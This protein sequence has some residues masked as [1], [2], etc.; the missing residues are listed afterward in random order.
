M[1]YKQ[2]IYGLIGYPIEHSRSPRLFAEHSPLRALGSY[3]LFPLKQI[4]DLSELILHH[5]P[6]G[7]NV[8]SPYKEAVL[9]LLPNVELS[10]EVERI[11]ATNVLSLSYEK[12]QLSH[13]KAYNTD[14]FGFAKSLPP[15]IIAEKPQ[16]LILGTGGAA[17]AVALALEQL[18]W[19]YGTY[20]LLSRSPNTLSSA[21][22]HFL[23]GDM[24]AVVSYESI[25]DSLGSTRLIINASPIGLSADRLSVFPY[26]QLDSSYF[27]YDLNYSDEMTPFL[28]SCHQYGAVCMD[29]ADMLSL[30]AEAS[31]SIWLSAFEG[32]G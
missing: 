13:C 27:C 25:A 17:R 11:G 1:S 7:L 12:G 32:E 30:Q 3:Q 10:P 22:S 14:V 23:R 15:S 5:S 6:R 19:E 21:L 28:E 18:G 26:E 16:A 29:G 31:W 20:R 2:A 24:N 4:S 8:T 9:S